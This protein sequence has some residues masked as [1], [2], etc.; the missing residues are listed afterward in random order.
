MPIIGGGGGGGNLVT[1]V[2]GRLGDVVATAADYTAALVTNAAD[3]SAAASQ[4]FVGPVLSSRVGVGLGYAAGAGGTVTQATSRSTA[5]T[6][7]KP[8]GAITTHTASLNAGAGVTFTVNNNIVAIGHVVLLTCQNDPATTG[9]FL[10][11]YVSNIQSGSFNVN[12]T[13]NSNAATTVAYV[14]NYVVLASVTA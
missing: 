11:P 1:S 7:N 12:Y 5:V 3:K 4:I 13:N 14:F 8:T 2:F 6:L 10:S 9:S